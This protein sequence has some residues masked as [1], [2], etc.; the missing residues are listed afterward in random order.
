MT[1]AER[2]HRLERQVLELQQ[3]IVQ[4]AQQA[5]ARR[6]SIQAAVDDLQNSIQLIFKHVKVPGVV[7]SPRRRL[8]IR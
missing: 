6:K 7:Y 5:D 1:D 4:L 2:I 8:L 3:E